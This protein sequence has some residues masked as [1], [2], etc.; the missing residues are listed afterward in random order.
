M[1]TITWF[2]ISVHFVQV[3]SWRSNHD[4]CFRAFHLLALHHTI[5]YVYVYCSFI[6][7]CM[8]LQSCNQYSRI[9]IRLQHLKHLRHADEITSTSTW[10][11][12]LQH[13]LETLT[14]SRWNTCNI[15]LETSLQHLKTLITVET[16]LDYYWNI[17]FVATPRCTPIFP[18]CTQH[19]NDIKQK[20]YQQQSSRSYRAQ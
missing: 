9:K 10:N 7:I 5:T 17:G 6:L 13:P 14:T 16:C 19:L 20:I 15:H 2:K 12:L 11:T 4:L 8:N 18:I 3:Q 1:T